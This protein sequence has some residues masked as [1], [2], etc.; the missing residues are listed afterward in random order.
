MDGS[1]PLSVAVVAK[2]PET[3]ARPGEPATLALTDDALRFFRDVVVAKSVLQPIDTGDWRLLDLDPVYRQESTDVEHAPVAAVPEV[4][5]ACSYFA[6]LAPFP[7]FDGA[8]AFVKRLRYYV[9]VAGAPGGKQAFFFRS[10]SASAELQRKR[11]TALVR[12]D[13]QFDRVEDKVFLFDE[14]IDC[15][16]F[17]GELFVT[18]KSDYRRIFQQFAALQARARAVA[19]S[20]NQQVPIKNFSAFSDACANQPGMADKL[21]AVSGRSYFPTLSVTTLEPVIKEFRLD[22]T[23][24]DVNGQQQLVFETDPAH[25]W[26]ILRL[27]DDDYLKSS[28]TNLQYESNSKLQHRPTQN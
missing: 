10:F 17:D 19:T 27:L 7:S 2:V 24:D 11:G 6:N 25:R 8:N 12:R 20:L 22:I 16:V 1:Q 28:L 15:F 26:L 4:Q 3:D 9:I 5:L 13:G 18:R 23:I 21:I 14:A